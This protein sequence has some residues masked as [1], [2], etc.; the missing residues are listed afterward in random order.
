[1]VSRVTG[2]RIRTTTSSVEAAAAAVALPVRERIR[3][4]IG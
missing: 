3:L 2:N 4:C 1:M